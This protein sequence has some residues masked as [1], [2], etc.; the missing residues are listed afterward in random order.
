MYG[1]SKMAKFVWCYLNCA[2]KASAILTYMLFMINRLTTDSWP[3]NGASMGRLEIVLYNSHNFLTA[4]DLFSVLEKI[5]CV[6]NF[7]DC[8]T[9]EMERTPKHRR[10]ALHTRRKHALTRVRHTSVLKLVASLF[11]KL[12]AGESI[13]IFG[14]LVI[15]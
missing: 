5:P 13:E 2:Q 1:N 3:T 9:P 11:A 7:Y 8:A 12:K 4:S 10:E 6:I 14:N 15:Q